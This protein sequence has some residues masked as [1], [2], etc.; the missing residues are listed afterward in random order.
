MSYE[1]VDNP[2]FG[3]LAIQ[4]K[5]DTLEE[6]FTDAAIGLYSSIVELDDVTP[7]K[8]KDINLE[9]TNPEQLLFNWLEEL[10]LLKD[11]ELFVAKEIE[12]VIKKTKTYK[13]E[14]TLQGEKINSSKHELKH[15]VKAITM[16]EFKLQKKKNTF[17]GMVVF[18]L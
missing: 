18:D 10:I 16:H 4:L 2:G 7:S 1:F 12:V 14:A 9:A 15:D 17:Q 3:D 6:V 8:T 13:L 11:S 5:G